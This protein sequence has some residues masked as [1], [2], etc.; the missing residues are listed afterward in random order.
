M[1]CFHLWKEDLCP[2]NACPLRNILMYEHNFN[3]IQTFHQM[4]L[5][6][7]SI[8]NTLI[9]FF[10]NS[11]ALKTCYYYCNLLKLQCP[12]KINIY[13]TFAT[14][15]QNIA[16][17]RRKLVEV[18]SSFSLYWRHTL[19]D[20]YRHIWIFGCVWRNRRNTKC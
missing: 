1:L 3:I 5:Y 10:E 2:N 11:Y 17:S 19:S 14:L 4:H 6:A 15:T 9:Y 18:I 20:T 8:C 16:F 13:V 12:L 7:I